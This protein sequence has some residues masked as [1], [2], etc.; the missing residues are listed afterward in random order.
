[1]QAE[2]IV[3]VGVDTVLRTNKLGTYDF[4]CC[5]LMKCL[6]KKCFPEN[7]QIND[8]DR[9]IL[10]LYSAKTHINIII[11]INTIK[12]DYH[13]NWNMFYAPIQINYMEWQ[14]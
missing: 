6:V 4:D 9:I 12:N 10:S 13:K 7:H 1:M 3:I 5:C 14:M 8:K 11:S 2:N